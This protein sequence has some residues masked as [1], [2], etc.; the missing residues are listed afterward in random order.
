MSNDNLIYAPFIGIVPTAQY[1][2]QV[3]APPYDVLSSAEA[4]V[5]AEGK[6]Y[7]FLH[8]SKA[9]IDFE[10]DVSPYEERVYLK[11]AEN[12]NNMLEKGV[13]YKTTDAVITFDLL[14]AE[15]LFQC[16]GYRFLQQIERDD[17]DGYVDQHY[18][19]F[20]PSGCKVDSQMQHIVYC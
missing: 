16:F 6:P 15:S 5:K 2:G 12:F 3:A 13:L 10:G 20:G 17:T 4:K 19:E 14:S 8:V 1:A 11:A 7:S 9:E 18:N